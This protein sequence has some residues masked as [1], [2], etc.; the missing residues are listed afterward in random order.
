M[1]QSDENVKFLIGLD[2]GTGT[3]RISDFSMICVN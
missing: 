3:Y 2:K 1:T